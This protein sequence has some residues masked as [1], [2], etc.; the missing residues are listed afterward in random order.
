MFLKL[1]YHF[2]TDLVELHCCSVMWNVCDEH[3]H[4]VDLF[5]TRRKLWG[6][7]SY[8]RSYELMTRMA[9]GFHIQ[10]AIEREC[11]KATHRMRFVGMGV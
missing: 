5:S 2:G 4:G 3:G 9:E 8:N 1:R 11:Y 10:S 6:E 7:I